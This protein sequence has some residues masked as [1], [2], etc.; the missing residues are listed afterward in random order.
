MLLPVSSTH[1]YIRSTLGNAPI[2][3]RGRRQS[4][5]LRRHGS[6]SSVTTAGLTVDGASRETFWLK[7]GVIAQCTLDD[8][9]TIVTVKDASDA[10]NICVA[11]PDGSTSHVPRDRFTDTLVDKL[12]RFM[13]ATVDLVV[14][15]FAVG[16]VN[17]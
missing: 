3:E 17:T 5:I 6:S 10:R 2:S 13:E 16:Y 11:L 12:F 1:G 4:R 8:E 7:R 14:M 15:D 9:V